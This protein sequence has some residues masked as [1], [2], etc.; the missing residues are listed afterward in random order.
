MEVPENERERC[1]V[2][3]MDFETGEDIRTLNCSHMFHIDCIDRWLNYNKKCPIC[4]VD[5][6]K[7]QMLIT[8]NEEDETLGLAAAAQ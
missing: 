5:M 4:R 1:T 2:C 3:L 6:D 7:L 8:D